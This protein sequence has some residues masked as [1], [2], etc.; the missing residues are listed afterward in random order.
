MVKY[1]SFVDS[2]HYH[3]A[4]VIGMKKFAKIWLKFVSIF[5]I[6][7]HHLHQRVDD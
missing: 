4:Y 7:L 6:I 1:V 5:M 3:I 2:V